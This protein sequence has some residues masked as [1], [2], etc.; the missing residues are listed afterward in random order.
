MKYTFT[1]EASDAN[2]ML[3]A[4][5]AKPYNEVSGLISSLL[6]QANEQNTAMNVKSVETV[7]PMTVEE[8]SPLE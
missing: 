8:T 7:E 5:G 2:Y 4:L 6:R 1:L 3:N